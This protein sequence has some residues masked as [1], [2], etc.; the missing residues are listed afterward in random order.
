MQIEILSDEELANL[1]GYKTRG[2]QRRWLNDRGWHF[3]ES[4]GG[5]P[6]VGRQYARTKL[7]VTLEVVSLAPPPPPNVPA[8]T[9]D[10]SKVR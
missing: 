10:V 1:T 5:R 8:W 4:R 2:W 7:G 3:V 9:P 6:L